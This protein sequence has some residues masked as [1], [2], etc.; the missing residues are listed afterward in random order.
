MLATI[1]YTIVAAW[2]L[3]EIQSGSADTHD[4][5]IAA[6]QQSEAIRP[7][8]VIAQLTPQPLTAGGL[9]ISEGKLH[10]WFQVPNYG[11]LVADNVA[12]CEFDELRAP[13]NI[14][15]LPYS[16][17]KSGSAWNYGGSPVIPPITEINGMQAPGWGMDGSTTLTESDIA[18]LH[19]PN[20]LEA[21]F[22]VMAT[23]DDASGRKHHAA[24]CIIFTFQPKWGVGTEGSQTIGSWSSK[25]CPWKSDND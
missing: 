4:L 21:V 6:R 17:C 11:P 10:V 1:S 14:A 2:T 20:M 13:N 16:N 18:G 7:R 24:S 8:L 12:L 23:Y 3:R 22:S 15:P 19:S 5:A 25:T 9:P